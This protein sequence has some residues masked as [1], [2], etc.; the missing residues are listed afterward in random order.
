MFPQH[1][2]PTRASNGYSDR[3]EYVSP[4]SSKTYIV[5]LNNQGVWECSC[6]RWTVSKYRRTDCKHINDVRGAMQMQNAQQAIRKRD[7]PARTPV[8]P[9]APEPIRPE[10]AISMDELLQRLAKLQGGN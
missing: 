8:A 9:A 10:P 1:I 5:A 2:I 3:F 4:S 7:A 6:P